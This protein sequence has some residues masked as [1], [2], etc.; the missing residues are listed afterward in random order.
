MI[1]S[2]FAPKSISFNLYL[3]VVLRIKT[4]EYLKEEI[5]PVLLFVEIVTLVP[6]FLLPAPSSSS[7]LTSSTSS[8]SWSWSLYSIYKKYPWLLDCPSRF[9]RIT[10]AQQE[11]ARCVVKIML[12]KI[13]IMIM[14][15][16]E[17]KTGKYF[18]DHDEDEDNW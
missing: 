10:F 9:S 15:F 8:S 7:S 3:V 11:T 2:N 5:I 14:T 6:L 16:A 12:R 17:Q 1:L 18:E 13:L 4:W